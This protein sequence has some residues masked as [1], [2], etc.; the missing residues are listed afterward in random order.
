MRIFFKINISYCYLG[1]RGI[2]LFE[3]KMQFSPDACYERF[4]GNSEQHLSAIDTLVQTLLFE[5][6]KRVPFIRQT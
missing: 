5:H 3:G 2:A 4:V 1:P 6:E